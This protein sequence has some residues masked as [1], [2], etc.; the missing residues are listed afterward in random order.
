MKQ[1][2]ICVVCPNGCQICVE[3]AGD[4]SVLSVTGAACSKGREYARQ[5][6][7]AP[8][9]TISSLVR[10]TGGELP[11]CSVRLTAPVPLG[12]IGRVME[13]IRTITLSAPVSIGEVIVSNVLGLGSDVIAT[14]NIGIKTEAS[15][16][17]NAG[18]E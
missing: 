15:H 4:G 5:E 17:S 7:V 8:C 10:V 13:V 18:S 6:T 12:E 14:R 2:L 16:I 3:T 9:R 11:L 1:E